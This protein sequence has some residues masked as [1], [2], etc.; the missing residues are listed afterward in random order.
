MDKGDDQQM[1]DAISIKDIQFQIIHVYYML[2]FLKH[3]QQEQFRD[4]G[5]LG[6]ILLQLGKS[7]H[8]ADLSVHLVVV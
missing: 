4:L 5:V 1:E 3:E 2:R 8:L 6:Q 7:G